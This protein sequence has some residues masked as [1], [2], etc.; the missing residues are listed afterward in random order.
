MIPLCRYRSI[1]G[2]PTYSSS[3]SSHHIL[4]VELWGRVEGDSAGGSLQL[5]DAGKNPGFKKKPAQWV[6]LGVFWGFYRV[7][8]VLFLYICPEERVFRIF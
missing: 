6:F 7:F 8:L 5:L 2:L 4:Q 3:S 1:S